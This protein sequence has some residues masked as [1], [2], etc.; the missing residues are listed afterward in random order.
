MP[1]SQPNLD[2]F[3]ELLELI[4]SDCFLAFFAELFVDDFFA[5]DDKS[6]AIERCLVMFG[7]SFVVHRKFS[8]RCLSLMVPKLV[9]IV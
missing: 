9:E 5:F 2:G 3:V 7:Y 4:H 6:I 1:D 8:H